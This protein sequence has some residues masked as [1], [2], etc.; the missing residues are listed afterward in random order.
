[1]DQEGVKCLLVHEISRLGRNTA[2]V[3][4]LLKILEGKGVSVYIHYLVL[5]FSAKE[6]SNQIFTTLEITIKVDLA[7]M[8]SED[9]KL[10]IKSG[11]RNSKA[12]GLHS[13]RRGNSTE[14]RENFLGKHKEVIK[15]QKREVL[16]RDY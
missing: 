9:L 13:C 2:E 14:N 11:I 16:Q 1:M 6:D 3:L 5:T 10:S 12:Q 4:N 7:R 15:Y 8:W